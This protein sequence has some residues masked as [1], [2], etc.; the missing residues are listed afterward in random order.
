MFSTLLH[1]GLGLALA[2]V[3]FFVGSTFWQLLKRANF[4]QHT[5]KDEQLLRKLI[6][7]ATLETAATSPHI[8]PFVRPWHGPQPPDHSP[9]APPYFINISALIT[10]NQSSQRLPKRIAVALLAAL[11]IF[12]SSAFRTS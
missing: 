2:F 11:F 10:A 8:A 9:G 1:I 5:I 6:T 4:L 7:R 12:G 3:A